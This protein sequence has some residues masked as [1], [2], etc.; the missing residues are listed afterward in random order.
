[1]V[2]ASAEAR[3]IVGDLQALLDA[4][5]A[6]LP[7]PQPDDVADSLKEGFIMFCSFSVFGML[8]ILGFVLVPVAFPTW[9]PHE[10]FLVA[11]A[12]TAVALGCLG[13]LKA[14]FHD[15][16]YLRSAIETV[17]LG[18]LCAGVAFGLGRIIAVSTY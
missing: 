1:M 4:I 13:A 16:L 18:G 10:L 14:N 17:V 2:V 12:V 5:G 7:V 6:P 3:A 8:P 11:C 9:G 15:K